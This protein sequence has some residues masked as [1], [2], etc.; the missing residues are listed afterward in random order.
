L[1]PPFSAAAY[2]ASLTS[3]TDLPDLSW[4]ITDYNTD[5]L[6]VEISISDLSLLSSPIREI[7]FFLL[8]AIFFAAGFLATASFFGLGVGTGSSSSFSSGAEPSN[9]SAFDSIS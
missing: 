3:V 1:F 2:W 9:F 8:F 4:S 7:S 5:F 6:P